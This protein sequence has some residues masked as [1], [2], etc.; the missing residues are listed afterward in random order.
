[1]SYNDFNLICDMQFCDFVRT[2]SALS[3][4]NGW[5]GVGASDEND[6][7]EPA[8]SSRAGEK[9]I[10]S[11]MAFDNNERQGNVLGADVRRQPASKISK[12]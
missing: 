6:K 1:M 7:E 2:Q 10:S 4:L 8:D 9:S 11:I 5:M 12:I 3:G